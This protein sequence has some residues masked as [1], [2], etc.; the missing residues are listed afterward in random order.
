MIRKYTLR[1]ICDSALNY[2]PRMLF[3]LFCIIATSFVGTTYPYIFGMLV[4]QV[5]Y[6]HN[7]AMFLKIVLIYGVIY[8]A[9]QALHFGLNMTWA[10]LMTRFLFD[11]RSKLFAKLLHLPAGTLSNLRSGEMIARID[12]DSGEFME[13]IHWNVFYVIAALLRLSMSL[14]FVAWLSWKLALL[15]FVTVP[16]SVF[17]SRYVAN[18]YKSIYADNR[19]KYGSFINWVME[20]LN[21]LREL[22][23][24]AATKTANR[25][26]TDKAAA[27]AR[28]RVII[29][30]TEL[31]SGRINAFIILVANISLYVYAGY[32]V[33]NGDTTVGAFVAIVDYFNT[34]SASLRY[35]NDASMRIK[36]NMTCINRVVELLNEPTEQN[37]PLA[38]ALHVG[39]GQ[40]DFENVTFGYGDGSQVLKDFSLRVNA[41]SR[42]AFVGRSGA[43]KSTIISLLLRMYAVE[44]GKVQVDGQN[45]NDVTMKSLRQQIGVINQ[46]ALMFDGSLR[47]N[48]QLGNFDCTDE[49]IMSACEQARIADFVCSQPAGLDTVIGKAGIGVSGGQKQRLSIARI[50]LKNPKIL[51]FDEAT[52]AL[53]YETEEMIRENWQTL[54]AGR[55]VIIIAHRLS[56]V[57]DAQMVAVLENGSISACGNHEDLLA[58]CAEY[59]ALF[60]EQY[61]V[62]EGA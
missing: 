55:T 60:R 23:L 45:V 13:F 47:F 48:L 36:N 51:I 9:E 11:I 40:I 32:L 20:M 54:C 39:G 37:I 4:D 5:F 34:M 25:S 35:L 58:S 49:E 33:I 21:G 27:V 16:L 38:Q 24:L 14:T 44:T 41:G 22:R 10:Y 31:V 50:L 61:F 12:H 17:F 7:K 59:Q 52:S 18:R 30:W 1:T 43:G 19:E 28:S 56:T 2:K 6:H 3:L 42:V 46:D 8:L 29:G 15:M 57:I 26:F 53:D 62:K